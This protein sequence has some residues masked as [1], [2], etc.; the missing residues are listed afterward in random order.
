VGARAVRRTL[1]KNAER[2]GKEEYVILRGGQLVGAS[3]S[4]FV[5][6]DCLRNIKNVEGSLKKVGLLCRSHSTTC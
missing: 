5:R 4:V 2:Y 6:S 1:N 3:L